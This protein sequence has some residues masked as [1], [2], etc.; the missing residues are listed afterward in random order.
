MAR[1]LVLPVLALPFSI[2]KV[3]VVSYEKKTLST[4]RCPVDKSLLSLNSNEIINNNIINGQ[5]NS[6]AGRRYII[7]D[8]IP[9]FIYP[10]KLISSDEEF[11]Q[12]Y[13]E[14]AD[15]YDMGLEWLFDSFYE[16][17]QVIRSQ[18]IQPLHI[19]TGHRVLEVGCGTGKDS[20]QILEKLQNTGELYLQDISLEM[21]KLAKKRIESINSKSSV[22]FFSGNASYLPFPDDYFDS[23]FH[24]GGINTFAEKQRAIDEMTRVTRPGGRVVLGDE[25]IAPWLSDKL[26]GRILS[27]ANSLYNCKPPIEHIPDF[28][29]EVSL[30]WLLGNAFYI[31]EYTVG[32]VP[33]AINIDLPIPGKRGGTLRSRYYGQETF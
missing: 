2:E 21:L 26:Y 22:E 17:E 14:G 20:I 4:Y 5:L 27:N 32:N 28:A 6:K 3:S 16:D 7:K 30:K 25:S 23:V 31:I 8:S 11:L 10:D 9:N 33:P 19:T 18:L 1:I 12:K 15:Q 24:F 29:Y 13:N